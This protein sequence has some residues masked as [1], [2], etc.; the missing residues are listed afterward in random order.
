M[1]SHK[2]RFL[3]ILTTIGTSVAFIASVAAIV[4]LYAQL[5][6]YKSQDA[7]Q[8]L[9]IA[10]QGTAIS[11]QSTGIA[12]SNES[13]LLFEEQ[14]NTQKE[15]LKLQEQS[16]TPQPSEIPNSPTGTAIAEA[17][18]QAASTLEAITVKRQQLEATQ[19]A[20]ALAAENLQ[21]VVTTQPAVFSPITICGEEEFDQIKKSCTSSRTE[22][23]G[24]V[25]CIY[26]NWSYQGVFEGMKFARQ[27]YKD[28]EFLFVASNT[29]GE[30]RER[31]PFDEETPAWS[32]ADTQSGQADQVFDS[33]FF[34]T[35]NYRVDLFI[36]TE[37]VQSAS[38][39][40][41]DD[42]TDEGVNLECGY[43]G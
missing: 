21:V 28:D 31:W 42:A 29:V 1:E 38:F 37:L 16:L 36:G 39:N 30:N 35:G 7:V 40:V 13:N 5:Q 27:W 17:I 25:R 6:D 19:T 43:L 32:V 33:I 2:H 23:V 24:N 4:S 22:F 10:Q 15:L 14:L 8:A 34:P 3:H 9:Q 18:T 12:L 11:L 20:I 41:V 26:A